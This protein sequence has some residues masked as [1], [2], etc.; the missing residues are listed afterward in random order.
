MLNVD[1]ID[2]LVVTSSLNFYDCVERPL[3][4]GINYILVP[5]PAGVG[6]LDAINLTYKDLYEQGAEWCEEEV[7]FNSFKLFRVID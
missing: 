7:A 4:N 1:N 6:S 2:N 5:N 3:H